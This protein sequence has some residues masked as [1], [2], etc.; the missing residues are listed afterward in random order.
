MCCPPPASCCLWL[1]CCCELEQA[2]S[3]PIPTPA[4]AFSP[5]ISLPQGWLQPLAVPVLSLSH[6]FCHVH[7]GSGKAEKPWATSRV[8]LTPGSGNTTT[9][10]SNQSPA[11][12]DSD[13]QA[14]PASGSP[15]P[16]PRSTKERLLQ[17]GRTVLEEGGGREASQ[18]P[19]CRIHRW[20]PR[21][22]LLSPSHSLRGARP[23]LPS[24]RGAPG[25][26]APAAIQ[27][28]GP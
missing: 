28:G 19:G 13:C 11:A 17:A 6:P 20:W 25:S 16:T 8:Y 9:S 24:N 5:L 7:G 3:T 21:Q 14:P 22:P 18:E 27:A 15:S 12:V 26:L 2:T 1:P 10:S 23:A 4:Q